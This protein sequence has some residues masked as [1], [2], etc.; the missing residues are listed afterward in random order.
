MG[1]DT[2]IKVEK[3]FRLIKK[4][5]KKMLDTAQNTCY[6]VKAVNKKQSIHSHPQQMRERV[7]IMSH[8]S[9]F[10]GLDRVCGG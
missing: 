7:H 2:A 9:F 1:G 6:T 4:R 3:G 8:G 5:K 10:M